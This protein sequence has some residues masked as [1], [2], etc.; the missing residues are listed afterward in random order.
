MK[1][2]IRFIQPQIQQLLQAGMIAGISLSMSVGLLA[3]SAWLI[4]MASTRPPILILEVAIV[5]VRFFGLG[6]GIVRYFARV[7][8]HDVALNIQTKI[9][10]SIYSTMEARMPTELIGIQRGKI[11]QGV[12][13]DSEAIQ[14]LWLRVALPWIAALVSGTSGIGIIYWLDHSFGI[15]AGII[16][17]GAMFVIPFVSILT[18]ADSQQRATEEELFDGFIQ[19]CD[20]IEESLVFGTNISVRDELMRTQDKISKN[21]KRIASVSGIS[22]SLQSLFA[23]STI[24][25]A[26]LASAH[27]YAI[28]KIP[29]V[30]IAVIVL[31]PL[32]IYDGLP[33]TFA[34]FS[35]V[36]TLMKRA[37]SL[38]PYL[39]PI[40]P[41]GVPNQL[42]H[43]D[44]I[45]KFTN[46]VPATVAG[47]LEPVSAE[48]SPGKPLFIQGRSGCGKSS[49]ISAIL[50]FVDY[51]GEVTEIDP[52]SASVMLQN[53]HL[54]ATSI[55]ENL[56]IGR[57]EVSDR[58]I[59]QILEVVELADL[60][61][62]MPEGLD[63]HIGP[64]GFN[65][66]GGEKQRLKLARVLLRHTSVYL[67][68]EPFEYLDAQMAQRIA[69][70]VERILVTKTLLIVSH[71]RLRLS[72]ETNTLG[73]VARM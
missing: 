30:N 70:K 48:A 63:T 71:L 73:L 25:L 65:L 36:T 13:S 1:K 24:G 59:M 51:T 23:G 64:Y 31:I 56:K 12:V 21:E 27:A 47:R 42:S 8:E 69:L 32:A 6:R 33:T 46:L 2:L 37:E 40:A 45:L 52:G 34:A 66:S 61:H 18:S 54:F 49:L 57:P 68:D 14:D 22:E 16:F 58:E 11:L 60:I 15:L 7:R 50:G 4:S 53:D 67:L 28:G 43:D 3:C 17:L 62:S 5:A 72:D 26:I 20:S 35:Q 19:A 10:Q 55:R 39:E 44:V 38:A 41:D 9:R 29:G